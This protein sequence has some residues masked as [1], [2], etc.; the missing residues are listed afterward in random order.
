M[1]LSM[2]NLAQ[3][4]LFLTHGV[5]RHGFTTRTGGASSGPFASFN[6]SFDVGDDP[7]AVRENLAL[8][9]AHMGFSEPLLRVH[10]V[11][12]AGVLDAAALLE[13]GFDGWTQ[14]P[15]VPA[16]AVVGCA[17]QGVLAVSAADCV[18]I[19]LVDK[20]AGLC[21]AV[22]AGWRST[23]AGV[24]RST[25]RALTARGSEPSRLIAAIGP[26]ICE[27]CYEVGLEVARHF[28][29][30]SDPIPGKPDK[31]SLDLGNAVEVSLIAAGLRGDRIDA[32]A[33]CTSCDAERFY[34]HRRDKGHTGR[35]LGFVAL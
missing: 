2:L 1:V 14:T 5:T 25:V 34:S 26:R 21:A 6:L 9:Q 35:G 4:E 16:D 3:S 30:S 29:E 19:L 8:L 17:S 23:K 28:P 12:G 15:T 33:A 20:D 18:P 10:Q 27:A 11:H 31:Y 7:R 32:L 13:T 22:H 24:I